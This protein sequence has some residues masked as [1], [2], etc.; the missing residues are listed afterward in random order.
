MATTLPATDCLLL[1]N[2]VYQMFCSTARTSCKIKTKETNN[3][4]ITCLWCSHS[5]PVRIMVSFP[6]T[7]RI[8][9]PM[10]HFPM[11]ITVQPKVYIWPAQCLDCLCPQKERH[12][13]I[14]GGKFPYS[15]EFKKGFSHSTPPCSSPPHPT[16]PHPAPSHPTPP[17]PA[18]PH[19]IPPG[20][21][22]YA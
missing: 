10:A 1:D 21:I 8:L 13:L 18:P 9:W 7:Q 5:V 15:K 20:R 22:V 2:K 12:Q 11:T 4:I 3:G 6:K 14:P 19:P 16:P 17:H